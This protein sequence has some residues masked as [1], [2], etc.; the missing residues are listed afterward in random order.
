MSQ[1]ICR[2]ILLK[3]SGEALMGQ[4]DYGIDPSVI[5]RVA[6]EIKDLA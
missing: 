3:L 4:G 5:A 2:R 1:L 6:G